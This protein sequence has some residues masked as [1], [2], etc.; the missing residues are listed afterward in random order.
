MYLFQVAFTQ[1]ESL[2]N[3]SPQFGIVILKLF[4]PP[5]AFPLFIRYICHHFWAGI[6]FEKPAVMC[7][8]PW[9]LLLISMHLFLCIKIHCAWQPLLFYWFSKGQVLQFSKH[10]MKCE[11]FC[12]MRGFVWGLWRLIRVLKELN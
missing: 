5:F 10:N 11:N 4:I 9:V 1:W 12:C 6:V 2:K 7:Q 3:Y 8:L